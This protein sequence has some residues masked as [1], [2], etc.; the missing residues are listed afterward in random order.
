MLRY[1]YY[2]SVT[3]IVICKR[4]TRKTT[5]CLCLDHFGILQQRMYTTPPRFPQTQ[6]HT[7]GQLDRIFE[8]LTIDWNYE[9]GYVD[10]SMHLYITKML[11]QFK[12]ATPK[13]LRNP[14][15]EHTP[16]I[17]GSVVQQ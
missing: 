7:H 8:G 10:I 9:R 6:L 5:L 2:P 1:G 12:Y 14:P 17:Y 16:I 13:N 15:H 3:M 11:H 4:I